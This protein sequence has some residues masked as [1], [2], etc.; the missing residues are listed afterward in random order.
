MKRFLFILLPLLFIFTACNNSFW[1]GEQ[2]FTFTNNTSKTVVICTPKTSFYVLAN[3]T[4]VF[5]AVADTNFSID[6]YYRCDLVF[7]TFG[8]YTIENA[9]YKT[10]TVYNNTNNT[11]IIKEKNNYIG[12]YEELIDLA[13]SQNKSIKDISISIEVDANQTKTFKIVDKKPTYYAY[14][15]NTNIPIDLSLI[16]FLSQ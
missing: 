8:N 13:N 4:K 3:E 9:V 7:H 10:V 15:K 11:I 16:S 14:Q 1:T 5:Y 12:T 2:K 6:N